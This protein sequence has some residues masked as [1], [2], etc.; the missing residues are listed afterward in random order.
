MEGKTE[1]AP[2]HQFVF[3]SSNNNQTHSV[4]PRFFR[5]RIMGITVS[6]RSTIV[7]HLKISAIFT[8]PT[9]LSF[10]NRVESRIKRIFQGK[11]TKQEFK[12][13]ERVGNCCQNSTNFID[14][15]KIG[16]KQNVG[17]LRPNNRF[18]PNNCVRAFL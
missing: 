9:T 6:L 16:T 8:A 15:L 17:R 2:S 3:I 12:E 18:L 7:F 11:K 5:P 13:F 10:C 1:A 14:A 4:C